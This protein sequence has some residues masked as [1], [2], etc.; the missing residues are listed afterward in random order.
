MEG[1]KEA[2]ET[3]A[4]RSTS[5]DIPSSSSQ[6]YDLTGRPLANFDTAH[7]G[8]YIKD[9]RKYLKWKISFISNGNL[10]YFFLGSQR[11]KEAQLR[12]YDCIGH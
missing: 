5:M 3:S 4:I 11:N 8:I 10:S 9:G 6:F 12:M 2:M 7:K 1:I